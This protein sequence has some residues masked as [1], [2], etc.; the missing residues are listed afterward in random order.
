MGLYWEDIDFDNQM[1]KVTKTLNLWKNRRLYIEHPKTR[2][3][4]REILTDDKKISILKEWR[5]IQREDLLKIG[6]NTMHAKQLV[7]F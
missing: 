5:K 7:F 2:N 3:S 6:N 4:W 1:I